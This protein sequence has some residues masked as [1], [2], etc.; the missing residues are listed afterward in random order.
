MQKLTAKVTSKEHVG[1]GRA[2]EDCHVDGGGFKSKGYFP[3]M[4]IKGSHICA[5]CMHKKIAVG[6]EG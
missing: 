6:V 5:S 2:N 4:G 1:P 3:C